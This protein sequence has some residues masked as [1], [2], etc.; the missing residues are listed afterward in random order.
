MIARIFLGLA[1]LG[2]GASA[3]A[4]MPFK[5]GAP[6]A[7]PV[8]NP[9]SIP[10]PSPDALKDTLVGLER[11]SWHAWQRHDGA[12]FQRFLSDDHVE[13][14]FRGITGK[15]A[16]VTSVASPACVVH[17]YT[18]DSFEVTRLN[19]TTALLTYHAAQRTLCDGH[20]VPSPVWVSSLY[21]QRADRWLNA[22]YQQ[23]QALP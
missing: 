22:L 12:F 15:A 17:G 13:V 5:Q 16:V 19:P 14:G 10:A 23:T 21:V 20:P 7:S 3:L 18:I 4:L 9:G 11:Q 8:L 1:S 6:V 2:L